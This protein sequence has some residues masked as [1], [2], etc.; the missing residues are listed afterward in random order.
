MSVRIRNR[1][2]KLYWA[3][4]ET[5]TYRLGSEGWEISAEQDIHNHQMRIAINHSKARIQGIS[6]I[7]SYAYQEFMSDIDFSPRIPTMLRFDDLSRQIYIN[8]MRNR[9]VTFQPVDYRPH[10]I[11]TEI[12]SLH[13]FA[14]FS[15]PEIAKNEVFLH[16]ANINQILEMALQKQAPHQEEIRRE[17][18]KRQEIRQMKTGKLHTELRLV[19]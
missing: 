4:W 7:D 3:G 16:E 19:A 8:S 12:K 14:N 18:I 11:D 9:E 10:Y 6:N 15:S 2:I 17:M 5:D 13:D 1:P